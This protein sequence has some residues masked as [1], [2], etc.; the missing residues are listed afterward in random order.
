VR[1]EKEGEEA[2]GRDLGAHGTRRHASKGQPALGH[3]RPLRANHA[4]VTGHIT[5]NHCVVVRMRAPV[6]LSVRSAHPTPHPTTTSLSSLIPYLYLSVLSR[7]LA[8]SRYLRRRLGADPEPR[9]HDGD[10][11]VAP[12][13]HL[14]PLRHFHRPAKYAPSHSLARSCSLFSVS[15]SMSPFATSFSLTS[16]LA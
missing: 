11:V 5:H 13:S 10:V 2:R 14:V 6:R 9:R 12:P 4:H 15:I 16:I 7:S 8:R 3:P 1:R